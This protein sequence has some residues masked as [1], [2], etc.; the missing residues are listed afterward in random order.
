MSHRWERRSAP[1]RCDAPVLR[2]GQPLR[3]GGGRVDGATGGWLRGDQRAA[4]N[5]PPRSGAVPDGSGGLEDRP[6]RAAWLD[7]VL[8]AAREAGAC[9]LGGARARCVQ[10]AA[11]R[12]RPRVH[13]S[14]RAANRRAG[15]S[16]PRPR[17]VRAVAAR[18]C[19]RA[20]VGLHAP[21]DRA[22]AH[23]PSNGPPHHVHQH[24][25]WRDGHDRR[26]RPRGPV[27]APAADDKT[28]TQ[29]AAA[30]RPDRRVRVVE[31]G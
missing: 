5:T 14:A 30:T 29:T 23:A 7:Q 3:R 25:H 20:G 26:R 4:G 10:A 28:P 2:T 13:V 31:V 22:T 6:S 1:R 18:L 16:P 24:V 15:R 11:R 9:P 8:A 19:R 12:A 21:G 17:W 27:G